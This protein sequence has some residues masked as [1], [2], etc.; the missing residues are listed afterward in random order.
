[1]ARPIGT[2]VAPFAK[3][4]TS[5]DVLTVEF[6]VG[7]VQ[8]HQALMRRD[9]P[10]RGNGARIDDFAAKCHVANSGQRIGLLARHLVEERRRQQERGDAV[11]AQMPS[12]QLGRQS[13]ILRDANEPGAVD[14]RAPDFERGCVE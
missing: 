4:S 7:P 1:M 8:V 10:H 14:E 13:D 6:S 5:N 12:Q 9:P 2:V 11:V 3:S